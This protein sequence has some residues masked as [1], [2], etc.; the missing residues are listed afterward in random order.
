MEAPTI[1]GGREK[2]FYDAAC[3]VATD[4]YWSGWPLEAIAAYFEHMDPVEKTVSCQYCDQVLHQYNRCVDHLLPKKTYHELHWWR[5][6]Y[7][8]RTLLTGNAVPC[9]LMCNDPRLKGKWDPN[10]IQDGNFIYSKD[11]SNGVLDPEQ[12][13]KLIARARE[14][15]Q[16]RLAHRRSRIEAL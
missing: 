11:R 15:V 12:R 1:I 9:C 10:F 8:V 16:D 14:L 3:N 5:D 13:E 4:T 6:G 7:R 2:R